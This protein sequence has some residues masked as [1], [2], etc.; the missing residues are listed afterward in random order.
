[1]S[2]KRRTTFDRAFDAVNLLLICFII[3]IAAY[4]LYFTVIAS[5]SDPYAVA[6]GKVIFWIKDLTLEPYTNV[7]KNDDIWTGYA[8]SIFNTVVIVI[9]QLAVTI[10]CSYVLSRRHL[11]G[12]KAI[13]TYFL[14]T[15][16]FGGGLIPSYLLMRDLGVVNTRLALI[17][18]AGM[19]VYTMIVARSFFQTNVPQELLEAAKIDGCGEFG[20]FLRI[21]I[22]VSGAIIA[23][24][25]LYA[26]V[27]HWNNWFSTLLYISDKKL[28]ELQYVLRN[29][30]IANQKMNIINVESMEGADAIAAQMRRKYMAQGMKYAIIFISSAPMLI[31]YPFVQKYFVKGVMIGSVKG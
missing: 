27:G 20:I 11:I 22:P 18:P 31:A 4:P 26:A 25:A 29:I 10:P 7:L 24:V 8:N 17:L 3:V 30:L 14:I 12:R 19:T 6:S 9:Y 21:V 23:V 28:Y 1:M 13:M 5:L 2:V 15:M 16:Y